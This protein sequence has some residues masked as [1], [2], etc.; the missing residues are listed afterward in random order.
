MDIFIDRYLEHHISH[1]HITGNVD[2]GLRYS[3]VGETVPNVYIEHNFFM[4]NGRLVHNFTTSEA[5]A[6]EC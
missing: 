2:G 3:S 1:S 6:R 4:L 5:A